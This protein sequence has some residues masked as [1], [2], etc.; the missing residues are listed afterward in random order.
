MTERGF[1]LS[2]ILSARI[3]ERARDD[4]LNLPMAG[5]LSDGFRY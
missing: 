5:G 2:D 3:A 1:G 4:F